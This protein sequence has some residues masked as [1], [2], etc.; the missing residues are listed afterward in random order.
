MKEPPAWMLF[1]GLT[2]LLGALVLLMLLP[3]NSLGF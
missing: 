1:L 2:F 3:A